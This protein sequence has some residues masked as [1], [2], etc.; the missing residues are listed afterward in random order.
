[1]KMQ[2][3][4]VKYLLSTAFFLANTYFAIA[5]NK[6]TTSDSVSDKNQLL[7]SPTV[8]EDFAGVKIGDHLDVAIARLKAGGYK[9]EDDLRISNPFR[10][11][12]GYNLNL[13]NFIYLAFQKTDVKGIF[14]KLK[15]EVFDDP[16]PDIASFIHST[17]IKS[18]EAIIWIPGVNVPEKYRDIGLNR[19]P[20]AEM[21]E[22]GEFIHTEGGHLYYVPV[23]KGS[24]DGEDRSNGVTL[25]FDYNERLGIFIY[26]TSYSDPFEQRII[27]R[28]CKQASK[29]LSSKK[30]KF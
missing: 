12:N 25:A 3:N 9:M 5:Q 1:M 21:M 20:N 13:F 10:N 8:K 17:R 7:P 16:H 24:S 18:M 11:C 6:S 4:A 15:L 22:R 19:Y 28:A 2:I 27:N 23:G 14:Y 29:E 26:N 30:P